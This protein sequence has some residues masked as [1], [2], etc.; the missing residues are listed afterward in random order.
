M[1]FFHCLFL[2]SGGGDIISSRQVSVDGIR[3][4]DFPGSR[5]NVT[6][7]RTVC[8]MQNVTSQFRQLRPWKPR[9]RLQLRSRS[10]TGRK[11]LSSQGRVKSAI[12]AESSVA[13]CSGNT[14]D[15]GLMSWSFVTGSA[16]VSSVQSSINIRY[17]SSNV[18][19]VH[20]RPR[21]NC[22]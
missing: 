2:A 1:P 12:N 7:D 15:D 20:F 18:Y 21:R 14:G 13:N 5:R 10:T 3:W 19:C 4:S 16:C 11:W 8:K 22:F 9:F 6:D 17:L